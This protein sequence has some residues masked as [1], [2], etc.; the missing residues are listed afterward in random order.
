MQ[1]DMSDGVVSSHRYTSRKLQE[2][3]GYDSSPDL[4]LLPCPRL[5][6]LSPS[7]NELVN[8]DVPNHNL[9]ISRHLKLWTLISPTGMQKG[10]W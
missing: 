1:E 4:C 3:G 7:T 8:V 10:K 6:V 9:N 5:D 2:Q